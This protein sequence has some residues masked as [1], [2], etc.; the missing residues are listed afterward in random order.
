MHD[1]LSDHFGFVVYVNQQMTDINHN[2]EQGI[3]VKTHVVRRTR[4]PFL[5]HEKAFLEES[6]EHS[7]YPSAEEYLKIAQEIGTTPKRVKGWFMYKRKCTGGEKFLH[8]QFN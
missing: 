5:A 1:S 3:T 6:Y 7:A 4:V 8:N 2:V